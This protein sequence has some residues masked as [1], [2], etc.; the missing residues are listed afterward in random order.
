MKDF[1]EEA[2]AQPQLTTAVF[3]AVPDDVFFAV[4]DLRP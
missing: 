3:H 4:L 2:R 1:V